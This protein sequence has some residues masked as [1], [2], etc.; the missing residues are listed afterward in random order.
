MTIGMLHPWGD[1]ESFFL[2]QLSKSCSRQEFTRLNFVAWQCTPL[3]CVFRLNTRHYIPTGAE[4]ALCDWP[5]HS[6]CPDQGFKPW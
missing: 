1:P 2:A 4:N 6:Q 5:L 3:T